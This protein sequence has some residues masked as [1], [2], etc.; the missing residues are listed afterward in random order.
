MNVRQVLERYPL[1]AALDGEK[2]AAWIDAGSE[3]ALRAGETLFEAGS[4]GLWIYVVLEGRVRVVRAGLLRDVSLG[5]Y[6]PGEVIGDYALLPPG[7]N[8]STCR[9]AT[10]GRLFQLPLAEARPMIAAHRGVQA[11]LRRWVQLNALT[12]VLREQNFLGFMSAPSV[13]ELREKLCK[14]EFPAGASIQA[15]GLADDRWFFVVDGDVELASGPR[16]AREACR[17]LGAGDC[18]GQQAFMPGGRVPHAMARAA[19][20]CL[21]L[22]RGGFGGTSLLGEQSVPTESA[23][24][25]FPWIGQ[26][27]VQDCG[28]AA[29]AMIRH[30]HGQPVTVAEIRRQAQIDRDGASLAELARLAGQLGLRA[31]AVEIRGAQ[32]NLVRPPAVVHYH[33]GHYV[34]L[35]CYDESGATVGDPAAG[36]LRVAR[37]AFHDQASGAALVVSA[38][39]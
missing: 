13:L 11:A 17:R 34:V 39:P 21:W 23:E 15:D 14:I 37:E 33:T 32:F 28:L 9:M 10:D 6:G 12:A 29:L 36:I 19:T 8:V 25:D 5:M 35:Y 31:Q 7:K 26:E 22:D 24:N 1:F 3:F 38:A 18:F 30:Y 27:A 20:R 4:P 16:P 2:L